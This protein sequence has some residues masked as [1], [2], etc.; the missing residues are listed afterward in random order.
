MIVLTPITLL[1]SAWLFGQSARGS[2]AALATALLLLLA[3]L[4][5]LTLTLD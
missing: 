4:W 2:K 5:F 1:A 3:G